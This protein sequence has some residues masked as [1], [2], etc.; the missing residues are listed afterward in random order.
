MIT[1]RL[2]G[3]GWLRL[4]MICAQA[5]LTI[6]VVLWLRGQYRSQAAIF[7]RLTNQIREEAE[8]EVLDS[9]LMKS[10]VKPILDTG[11][12]INFRFTFDTDSIK[13]ITNGQQ[14][15]SN[16]FNLPV[17]HGTVAIAFTDTT[18]DAGKGKRSITLTNRS[19]KTQMV[20]QGV[21]LFINELTDSTSHSAHLTDSLIH[22]TDSTLF[23]NKIR[24]KLQASLPGIEVIQVHKAATA[25]NFPDT[26]FSSKGNVGSMPFPE[27]RYTGRGT[28]ILKQTTSEIIF[29]LLVLILTA[30]A[31]IVSFRSLKNQMVLNEMRE[32]FVRNISHELKT[33]VAT[34][35]VALEALQNFSRKNDPEKLSEYLSMAGQ[36]M[37]RLELLIN[38]VL[39]ISG[40]SQHRDFLVH[41]KIDLG[42]LIHETVRMI[43]PQAARVNASINMELPEGEIEFTGDR[44][45]LQGLLLNLI[46]N[47]LK[48]AGP[49][50]VIEIG[51]LRDSGSVKIWVADHGPGIPE[52]YHR[53]IFDRFF[54]I[55]TG[56]VHSVKGHGLGLTYASHIA[57]LH[58]G[59]IELISPVNG[60]AKF[61]IHLPVS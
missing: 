45:Q 55:S 16:N 19:I 5:L 54:R 24:A 48:Y 30:T 32:D 50:P 56:D 52:K 36:E 9:V 31:F 26:F 18:C 42:A 4:L 49:S 17:S 7:D 33:P 6:M 40:L 10:V 41:E 12:R 25:G 8:R 53:K 3:P 23:L 11:S 1:K 27:V 20:I 47:A 14:N 29:A 38:R 60:G 61:I 22:F 35:K 13:K 28:Y 15:K 21:K 34:V 2:S 37:D 43:T 58:H 39:N 44:L 59:K 46:D 51:L 57:Q